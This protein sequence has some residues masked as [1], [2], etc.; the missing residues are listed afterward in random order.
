MA[1]KVNGDHLGAVVIGA[2][3]GIAEILA[4]SLADRSVKVLITDDE[5]MDEIA[6][7]MREVWRSMGEMGGGATA[8]NTA[9]ENVRV[10]DGDIADAEHLRECYNVA[11][12]QYQETGG[13]QLIA[14]T[15]GVLCWDENGIDADTFQAEVLDK[16]GS[17][18]MAERQAYVDAILAG[19]KRP[20]AVARACLK[21]VEAG[22][23][24][25][26]LDALGVERPKL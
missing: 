18:E 5:S 17:D 2:T 7:E 10:L 11:S 3:K 26:A 15:A 25:S 20:A 8:S 21:G 24:D 16:L 13:V 12:A 14:S 4:V 1:M 23:R 19:G 9:R 6:K 22:D